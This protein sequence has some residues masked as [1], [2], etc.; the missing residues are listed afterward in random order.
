MRLRFDYNEI[1][2]FT[3]VYLIQI[4]KPFTSCAMGDGFPFPL[5]NEEIIRQVEITVIALNSIAITFICK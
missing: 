3:Y 2:S 5:Q 1:K 4:N